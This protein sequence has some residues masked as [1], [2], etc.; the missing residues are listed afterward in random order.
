MTDFNPDTFMQEQQEVTLD[1]TFTAIPAGEYPGIIKEVIPGTTPNGSNKMDVVWLLDSEEVRS[2]TG[3]EEPT[4]KQTVWLDLDANN[5]LQSGTNKNIGLGKLREALGQNDGSPWSPTM[6][7]GCPAI[8]LIEP[9]KTGKYTNV[10]NV[11]AR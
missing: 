8:V 3:M 6:L 10:T 4:C 2:H 11:Q 7:V 1:T 5:H 9:D